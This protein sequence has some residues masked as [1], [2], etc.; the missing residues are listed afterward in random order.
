VVADSCRCAAI[1]LPG[2]SRRRRPGSALHLLQD[3]APVPRQGS[4]P[5]TRHTRHV[6]KL[7]AIGEPTRGISLTASVF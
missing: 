2:P 7:H 1:C 3:A 4:K 5:R 6:D